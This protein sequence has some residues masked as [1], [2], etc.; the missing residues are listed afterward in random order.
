MKIF[1]VDDDRTM[2]AILKTL[3]ELE[4]HRITVWEGSSSVEILAQARAVQPDLMLLDVHLKDIDGLEIVR[5]VR[6]DPTLYCLKVLMTSGMD[7]RDECLAAGA[8]A[9]I[10]KPY[11]PDDLIGKIRQVGSR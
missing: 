2:R 5:Q 10:L 9:F 1:L 6:E 8:D 7:L 4:H 3:L 11:M